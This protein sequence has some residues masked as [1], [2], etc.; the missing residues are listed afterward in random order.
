MGDIQIQLSGGS[1]DSDGLA[2]RDNLERAVKSSQVRKGRVARKKN[3]RSPP[4]TCFRDRER[5]MEV[6][7]E[8]VYAGCHSQLQ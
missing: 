4:E 5:G 7:D 8:E 6:V 1:R 2:A 3:K